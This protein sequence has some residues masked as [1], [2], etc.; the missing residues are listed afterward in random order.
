MGYKQTGLGF[1]GQWWHVGG[2]ATGWRNEDTVRTVLFEPLRAAG[3]LERATHL[4]I[5]LGDA[6]PIESVAWLEAESLSWQ[7]GVVSMFA[8]D[9]DDPDWLFHLTL[10]RSML[11][12]AVGVG[13]EHINDE[14]REQLAGWIGEWARVLDARSCH[15]SLGWLAPWKTDYPRPAPS[16]PSAT[17]R[18]G[19]LDSYFGRTWHLAEA[20]RS[21]AL[22][23]IESAP[24][25]P[26]AARTVDGDV[27]RVAF[28]ADL[29]D[30]ASIATA[31]SH[32]EAWLGPLVADAEPAEP[33]ESV[34]DGASAGAGEHADGDRRIDIANPAPHDPLTLYD[35]DE[36][37]GYKAMVVEPPY[38]I[39]EDVYEEMIQILAA[40]RLP[41][42]TPVKQ[43]RLIFPVRSD[44]LTMHSRVTAEGFEMALYP[45][46]GTFWQVDPA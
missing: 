32:S 33:V 25:P 29:H 40:G 27:V 7:D 8:G 42:G 5:G 28:K 2:D 30:R 35:A 37:V 39:D 31:R 15:L 4:A 1:A 3:L 20:T 45:A 13:A 24:L 43:I 34:A 9:A 22:A 21:A 44:A 46:D 6:V 16:H 17:W 11:R 26:D 12:I 41:D 38:D 36:Q 14:L 10:D 23:A 19:A 18:L